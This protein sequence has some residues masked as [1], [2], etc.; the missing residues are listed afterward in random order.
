MK[1]IAPDYYTEFSCIAD[2]CRHNCCIGWEIDVDSDT[3]EYYRRLGGDFGEKLMHEIDA[4]GEAAHFILS[5]DEQCPFLNSRNLCDIITNLGERSLCQICADHPRYRNFFSDREEIG[6]GLCC[7]AAGKI[8]LARDA[9]MRTVCI[10]DDGED[11][12]TFE[13]EAVFFNLRDRIF[14]ILQNR[15]LSVKARIENMLKIFGA[16]FP[17]K[18][19]KQWAGI[20]KDLERLDSD[21]DRR[22]ELL[23]GLDCD[24]YN[25]YETAFEQLT[26]YFIYRHLSG[27]LDDGK[28]RERALLAAVGYH[29]IH[30][31]CC[32]HFKENGKIEIDDIV[33]IA[34]EYSAEIEY[35]EENINTLTEILKG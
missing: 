27:G 15:Q 4:S 11:E 10:E 30:A 25:G 1:L 12:I 33:E 23:E 19:Y 7:E 9:K 17:Q 32:A 2:K 31:L 14:D 20:F 5:H 3:Y 8:I 18:S 29:I 21:W 22:L 24:D 13:D 28:L 35:S 26:V 6:L 16:S 34:R